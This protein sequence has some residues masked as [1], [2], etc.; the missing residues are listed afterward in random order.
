MSESEQLGFRDAIHVPF[1]VVVCDQR[2]SR[3]AKAWLTSE[4]MDGPVSQCRLWRNGS[5]CDPQPDWHG[6]VDPFL[7]SEV[8]EAGTPFRLMIR[9]ECFRRLRH[10]FEIDVHDRGGTATCHSVCD[11]F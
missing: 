7:D 1:V 8:I 3:G 2:A 10:D 9:K 6:V 11:V 5:E 4:D